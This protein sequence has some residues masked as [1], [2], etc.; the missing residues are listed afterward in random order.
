MG[1]WSESAVFVPS[2]GAHGAHAF[3]GGTIFR[4]ADAELPQAA[5]TQT[6]SSNQ[7]RCNVMV[8]MVGSLRKR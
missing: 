7:N 6:G 8:R 3:S 5:R 4:Q 1:E 2:V